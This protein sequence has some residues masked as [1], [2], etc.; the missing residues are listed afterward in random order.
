MNG[1][2]TGFGALVTAA[3]G[4]VVLVLGLVAGRPD[5][6]V[7]GAPFVLCFAWGWFSRPTAAPRVSVR[8]ATGPAR[9]GTV[10]AVLEVGAPRGVESVRVRV[11]SPG[12]REAQALL[13]TDRPREVP[14]RVVTART[15]ATRLFRVDH[16]AGAFDGVTL[17]HP[18]VAGPIPVVVHPPARE[19]RRM[20]LPPRLQ[21]LTGP[22][23]SRRV[24]DGTDLH[25]VHPFA[26]G[27]RLRRIDWR[28]TA[29][30]SYD[31]QS[32]RLGTLY[33]RR[34]FATAD[35]TVM[36]VVDSRDAVGP[37]VDT[38]GGGRVGA[39]DEPISLDI[40]R[41]A[42]TAVA[43]ATVAAGDRVGLDDLG[44]RRRPV[45]PAG[46]RRQ[47]DRISTRL[48]LL[49]PDSFPSPRERAPQIPAA[50]LVVLCSTFLDEEAARMAQQWRAQAH[51]VVAVDTLPVVR[52]DDLDG[53]ALAAYELVRL[54]R[55]LR[56][57]RLRR[58]DVEV[59]H[60]CGDPTGT[61]A[62][63]GL[64][65]SGAALGIDAAWQLLSRPRRT[66]L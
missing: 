58:A 31:P 22:H 11:S 17:T 9:A 4:A 45:P 13:A 63:G 32:G 29:R 36:L 6:A 47:L 54:E 15:G 23:T 42:A 37:D 41:E 12:H 49:A 48:A 52:T 35:A 16:V 46:G 19:L 62:T 51:R 61:G 38:W 65:G 33:T 2:S 30:R 43:R 28:V 10:G 50:A 1:R 14:L 5:V 18:G 27:D 59:V 8:R 24:G 53:V 26:P 39:V 44:L 40:A 25:D 34:T 57:E 56:L 64:D 55:D 3:V 60:W 21:G 66:R 20:P 7:L